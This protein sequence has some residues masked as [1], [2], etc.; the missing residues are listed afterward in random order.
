M[1]TVLLPLSSATCCCPVIQSCLPPSLPFSVVFSSSDDNN[2]DDG[3]ETSPED[4]TEDQYLTMKPTSAEELGDSFEYDYVDS[5]RMTGS[6]LHSVVY[7]KGNPRHP[8][9]HRRTTVIPRVSPSAP[10]DYRMHMACIAESDSKPRPSRSKPAKTKGKSSKM[11]S[12]SQPRSISDKVTHPLIPQASPSAPGD[13]RMHMAHIPGTVADSEP[14]PSRSK[15]VK[16][17]G[18][19]SRVRSSSQPRS[20]SDKVAPPTH[21]LALPFPHEAPVLR[22]VNTREM[23]RYTE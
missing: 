15:P 18:K 5:I 2:T 3:R 22:H 23:G 13:Y 9:Q 12:S 10:E 7:P 11:R 8:P 17:H 4:S 20:A 6:V 19:S 16:T 21:G 1:Q 14:L